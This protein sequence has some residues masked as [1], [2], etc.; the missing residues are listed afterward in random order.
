MD[1]FRSIEWVDGKLRLLDQRRLPLETTYRDYISYIDVASAIRNM[2]VRGAP[3]I[4]VTAAFGLAIAAQQSQAQ[5][6][7]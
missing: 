7:S 5:T 1:A 3:A 6:L 2:V 4:G